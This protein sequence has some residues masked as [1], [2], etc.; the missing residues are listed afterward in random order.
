MYWDVQSSSVTATLT[1]LT[2]SNSYRVIV[3]ANL[4][5]VDNLKL[6]VEGLPSTP[7]V[8]LHSILAVAV[9]HSRPVCARRDDF[10]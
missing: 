2:G 6:Q 5:K 8:Q 3:P 4:T 10:L 7:P 1:L 9:Q